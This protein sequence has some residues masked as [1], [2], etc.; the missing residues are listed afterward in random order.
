MKNMKLI[1]EISHKYDIVDD[2]KDLFI[3]GVFSTADVMNNN[4]RRY[5]RKVLEREINRVMEL[6]ESKR[7]FGE[8][9]HPEC[10]LGDTEILT[11]SGW[12]EIKDINDDEIVATLNTNT[13]EIEY[14]K[15]VR[16]ISSPY[17]GKMC[18]F[19]GRQI[20][21]LFTPTHRQLLINRCEKPYFIT[22][23]E[24]LKESN[25]SID[26][27]YIPK[28]G[29][30]I[31]VEQDVMV[32]K[33][34]EKVYSS[35]FKHNVDVTLSMLTFVRFLGIWL[36]EGSVTK[37]GKN[38][39]CIYQND[40]PKADL[41]REMLKEFPE[42]MTWHE[43]KHDKRIVFSLSD[44]RLANLL[45][46]LGIC[47]TKYIPEFV[48][49]L[50]TKYLEELLFWFGLGDG[51]GFLDESDVKKDIFSTSERLID[52]FHEIAFKCGI[53]AKKSVEYCTTD[54]TFAD[55]IIKAEN[56]QPLY[57]L[58]ILSTKGIYTD[59][60]FLTV[61]EEDFDGMVYCVEVPNKNFYV[62]NNKSVSFFTGN[63]PSIN[64]DRVAILTTS[65]K[66]EDSSVV[67]RAKVLD[68]PTGNIAKV[69]IKE[70]NLGISSRG[71]GTVNEENNFVNEDF[72]LICYD[73]V[74]EPSNPGSWVRGIYEGKT[75]PIPST[76]PEEPIVI[77]P[78]ITLDEARKEYKRHIWQ[79]LEKLSKEV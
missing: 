33:G 5:P 59:R 71:L 65:L 32:L 3:E 25:S 79:V 68:T 7:L 52:D 20:N 54:Y 53:S 61:T 41:I 56:K 13:K 1:T 49:Q 50:S 67:G 8:L 19:K 29:T 64:L 39:I 57:F 11:S 2:G 21:M 72:N 63:S 12:K 31:G 48:K 73:L 22:S 27:S 75:F 77:V 4:G 76:E 16:K 14:Q 26:H 18:R 42:E 62:R 10:V 46:P 43:S 38:R 37:N 28:V 78:K 9:S 47:Y 15:I 35:N 70:G 17:K 58:K 6:V 44:G 36:A 60:R 23:D 66:W 30:W 69:L 34:L 40:G 45:K 24:I 51:R 74:G 55:R